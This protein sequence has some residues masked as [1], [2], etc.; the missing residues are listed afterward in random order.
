MDYSTVPLIDATS[1]I[2]LIKISAQDN[3]LSCTLSIWPILDVPEYNALSYTWGDPVLTEQIKINGS[4]VE[5]RRNSADALRQ[6]VKFSQ[7]QSPYFWLDALCIDQTSTEEKNAQVARMADIF[8]KAKHVLI[9]L[10][11]YDDDGEYALQSLR[12]HVIPG[13]SSEVLNWRNPGRPHPVGIDLPRCALSFAVL[14][15]R[16]YWKRVWIIQEIFL[17]R[18]ARVFCGEVSIPLWLF[19]AETESAGYFLQR[20]ESID[21]NF[22][23]Y[24]HLP[25]Y[26]EIGIATPDVLNAL[27]TMEEGFDEDCYYVFKN[28]LDFSSGLPKSHISRLLNM[29][30]ASQCEDPRDRIYGGLALT[31]WRD[32][33][34]ILP[35]YNNSAY[36][37]VKE[38]L[39][40]HISY[41]DAWKV[42]QSLRIDSND[43]NIRS[44]IALR[45]RGADTT[46][47][48][49]IKRR[50]PV[51]NERH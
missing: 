2:R 23:L 28:P 36:E 17:A 38:M 13:K 39:R 24:G 50:R 32:T 22:R 51:T 12:S 15:R 25:A 8:N 11:G 10:G 21:R 9:C 16:P 42:I 46:M 47:L 19:E 3:I 41:F 44:G 29:F 31:D 34:P 27:L 1:S 33:P 14:T 6:G 4:L 30:S 49:K 48:D 26:E 18:D 20:K 5:V 7:S 45:Q 37:L 40:T 35:D 43:V